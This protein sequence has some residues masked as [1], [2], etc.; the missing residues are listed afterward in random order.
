MTKQTRKDYARMLSS[1]RTDYRCK[2]FGPI[3]P[4]WSEKWL[5]NKD[6][7]KLIGINPSRIILEDG[8]EDYAKVSW[9]LGVLKSF[10]RKEGGEI[11]LSPYLDLN[12][13]NPLQ[14]YSDGRG[15]H[16]HLIKALEISLD[17]TMI[18]TS[19]PLINHIYFNPRNYP[20]HI[21]EVHDICYFRDE[22]LNYRYSSERAIGYLLSRQ[23][24]DPRKLKDVIEHL[25]EHADIDYILTE[26]FGGRK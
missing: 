15:L 25:T 14:E 22:N 19:R 9:C 17:K 13:C 6:I 23:N 2:L 21:Q 24:E 26:I 4:A 7:G 18:I 20:T 5:T 1:L 11:T 16:E 12:K 10:K 8:S 3:I